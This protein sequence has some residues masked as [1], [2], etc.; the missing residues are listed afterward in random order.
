MG[1]SSPPGDP[2]FGIVNAESIVEGIQN[3]H[4][5]LEES[6]VRLSPWM[7]LFDD[8]D[9]TGG[10]STNDDD[11]RRHRR[12]DDGDAPSD[13]GDHRAVEEFSS[14]MDRTFASVDELM[15]RLADGGLIPLDGVG[16]D[17]NN[18]H[19]RNRDEDNVYLLMASNCIS[20]AT[21]FIC[22]HCL[23]LLEADSLDGPGPLDDRGI[24]NHEVRIQPI[25]AHLSELALRVTHIH[26]TLVPCDRN[27]DIVDDTD[28]VTLQ[29]IIEGY[30]Q[31]QRRCLRARSKLAISSVADLRRAASSQ[32]C[33][34]S[35]LL[36]AE[37]I[38]QQLEVALDDECDGIDGGR[39]DG[40]DGTAGVSRGQPHAQAITVVLGEAS[41]LIQPLAAWRDALDVQS[42]NDDDSVLLRRL[43]QDSIELLDMEAQTL[44]ATV[45]SWFSSDQRGIATLDN[46]NDHNN[47][48]TKSDLLSIES[49]LEE[50]AWICQL[51]SRYC[52][53]SEQTVDRP[54]VTGGESRLQDLLTEQSLHYSTLETRLATLQFGQ[55]L[56]LACP[57]HIELGRPSLQVP[58]IVEDTHFIC[59]RAIERAAGTRSERAVWTVGHWVCEVWG[60]DHSGGMTGGGDGVNGVYRALMEGVGCSCESNPNETAI[61]AAG[62]PSPKVENAF[63]AALLEAVDEDGGQGDQN[64]S[65]TGSAT[66]SAPTSGGLSSF[67]TREGRDRGLQNMIDSE[68]CALNGISAAFNACSALSGLFADLVEEHIDEGA[69][70]TNTCGAPSTKSP[71]MLTF[72]RDELNSHSRS[73]RE[74]LQQRVRA[75]VTDLCGGDDVFDCDGKPCLQNLR[76]FIEKEV[77]NLDSSS[78]RHLEGVDRLE[79]E[80]IGPVRRSQIFEEIR[81]DKCDA[82]VVLQIA[83]AVGSKSAEIIL[84]VLLQGKTHFNEYGAML[85]SKQ[86]RL[87]QNLLCGLV[88][89]SADPGSTDAVKVGSSSISTFSIL[90]QFSR[91]NQAVSILQLEKPSDWL[92]FSYKVGESDETNLTP[93]EIQKIMGLRVDFSEEAIAR[94]C[95]Q[96]G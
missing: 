9:D 31:Y 67:F 10:S 52:L 43:C 77:Y 5:S 70:R 20:K 57:Q 3:C 58:S 86:V 24:P 74:L 16:R 71:S 85:L 89:E 30:S 54:G 41:S 79:S 42:E 75:L 78:F 49:S 90:K 7:R 50:M 92:A 72:A 45:G 18:E 56:S 55:A 51:I 62:L 66:N 38:R 19:Y 35:D 21:E 25:M 32:N 34:V 83:E 33:H 59:V 63:A 13:Y 46:D 37:R 91:V 17:N 82:A 81:K 4:M 48:A 44:A 53:Y 14:C 61:N 87:L 23:T 28:T 65:R 94:V 60:V 8:E 88:L 95:I 73:Y 27:R 2:S 64:S 36:E 93:D 6:R 39:G 26:A 40:M 22:H 76:L 15:S 68:I 1:R 96:I 69:T 12:G 11:G 84:Q 47:N 80:M 29:S